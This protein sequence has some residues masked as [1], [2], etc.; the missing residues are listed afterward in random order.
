MHGECRCRT[1]NSLCVR[2]W[3]KKHKGACASPLCGLSS[4]SCFTCGC[5]WVSAKGQNDQ[6]RCTHA[7]YK[8]KNL[9]LSR[10]QVAFLVSS[11]VYSYPETKTRSSSR[12]GQ[13]SWYQGSVNVWFSDYFYYMIVRFLIPWVTHTDEPRWPATPHRPSLTICSPIHRLQRL[14]GWIGDGGDNFFF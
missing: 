9:G 1:K 11:V 3:I 7:H 6:T 2:D 4:G 12:R 14:Q 13:W 8:Q 10:D 5:D